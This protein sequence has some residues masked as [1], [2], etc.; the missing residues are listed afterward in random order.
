MQ[1]CI[2]VSNTS[3][4][5]FSQGR[6]RL[7][8]HICLVLSLMDRRQVLA[9]SLGAPSCGREG[10]PKSSTLLQVEDTKT[11]VVSTWNSS[12]KTNSQVI[13]DSG[14]S[15]W[16]RL[17]GRLKHFYCLMRDCPNLEFF[18]RSFTGSFCVY[19]DQNYSLAHNT[20]L[21]NV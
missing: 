2:S 7:K 11:R 20:T 12:P 14:N 18:F 10:S 9:S 6:Y 19:C 5:I 13:M 1:I 17:F 4:L 21:T 15:K 16:R 3:L 8:R